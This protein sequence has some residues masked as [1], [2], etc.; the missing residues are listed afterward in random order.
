MTLPAADTVVVGGGV[1]GCALAAELARRGQSVVVVERSEPG[2][3]ASSAA[4]GMLSPQADVAGPS[5]LFDLALESR[6][7]YARWAPALLE[8][9]GI[10][11]GYRR[12]GLYRCA[13]SDEGPAASDFEWQRE[14]GLR[15]ETRD[16]DGVRGELE[17]RLSSSVTRALFFPDEAVV[18]PRRLARAVWLSAERRGARVLSD[19]PV[20]RLLLEGGLCVGVETDGG[21]IPAGAV[22]NAAGA[23][24]ASVFGGVAAVPVSPVR[25]Q[26][27]EVRLAGRPLSAVVSS[28]DAY[29]VPRPDGTALI[30]STSEHVGFRK[31]VTAGA[32]QTLLQAAARLLP[33]LSTA[34]FE[35]AWS[36][37]RPG[38]S[39][40]LPILGASSVRGLFFATG[41]YRNGILL[42]PVTAR[43][44]ADLLVEGRGAEALSPFS[45]GRF[46]SAPSLA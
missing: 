19:T 37:L 18:H 7:L 8:E 44:M 43:R 33:S 31:E 14:R 5:A 20:R 32:V 26:I 16:R 42:A 23:W 45:A 12:T 39:D 28:E 4:A 15:V 25:G 35:T 21:R 22:V 3:E 6:E 30:G 41:H 17:G 29:V 10:D 38:T 40:D 9:T 36:G 13:F 2:G 11:V 34:R 24:A 46:A 27:V 1:I